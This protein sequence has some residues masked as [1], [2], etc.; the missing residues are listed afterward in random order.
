M[1]RTNSH[2][3]ARRFRGVKSHSPDAALD[4]ACFLAELRL[5]V[6]GARTAAEERLARAL[7]GWG[8]R[9]NRI[10][11]RYAGNPTS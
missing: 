8:E 6:E 3:P 7:P 10:S 1:S 4:E 2:V 9:L 11:A 5:A